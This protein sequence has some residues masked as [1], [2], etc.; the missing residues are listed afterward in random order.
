MPLTRPQKEDAVKE[1]SDLLENSKI[2]VLAT[3]SGS[4]VKDLQ[5]LRRD[6]KANGTKLK[7]VKNRL[8]KLALSKNDKLKNIDTSFLTGQLIYGFNDQ[9]EAAPAQ[10]L[11]TFSK[12]N[13]QMEF[14]GAITDDGQLLSGEDVKSLASLPSKEQLRAQLVGTLS[15][16]SRNLITVLSGNI[17]GVMNVL[18]ARAESIN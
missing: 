4:G 17:R 13:Q 3:Y 5:N 8:F 10:S 2:V 1:I 15:A 9:D 7:I 18:V 14:V 6:A 11:A 16:P 12:V